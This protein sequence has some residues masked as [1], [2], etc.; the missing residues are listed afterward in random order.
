MIS[1]LAYY[2]ILAISFMFSGLALDYIFVR[3]N[4]NIRR[5]LLYVILVV[6]ITCLLMPYIFTKENATIF[7]FS[8]ILF[9]AMGQSVTC[10]AVLI[11]PMAS[12]WLNLLVTQYINAFVERYGATIIIFVTIFEILEVRHMRARMER[13]EQVQELHLARYQARFHQ[14]DNNRPMLLIA[15]QQRLHSE[16]Y[17]RETQDVVSPAYKNNHLLTPSRYLLV[18]NPDESLRIARSLSSL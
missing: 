10:V 3:E 4:Q 17:Q 2:A 18:C 9:R 1:G 14:E 8:A 12:T 13:M 16:I 5:W 11:I 6:G 15:Y 7:A